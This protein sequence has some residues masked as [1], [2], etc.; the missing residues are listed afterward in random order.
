MHYVRRMYVDD[1]KYNFIINKSL[2][3]TNF[4]KVLESIIFDY[5]G[6]VHNCKLCDT[7]CL[8]YK[9]KYCKNCIDL[10]NSK[11]DNNDYTIRRK[12]EKTA[13][14]IFTIAKRRLY[15]CCDICASSDDYNIY[16]RKFKYI[17]KDEIV[18]L[19]A[20]YAKKGGD[21]K[22]R[23]PFVNSTYTYSK[24]RSR[25]TKTVECK[26]KCICHDN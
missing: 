9:N 3:L 20:V 7:L 17:P 18:M 13:D 19:L 16:Y 23:R 6:M 5:T 22:F 15:S 2:N 4:P 12:M 1:Y 14:L 25:I 26:L 11:F 21:I 8:G 10:L 24:S